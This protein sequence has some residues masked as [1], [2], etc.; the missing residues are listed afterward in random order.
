MAS[1]RP[2]A[3]DRALGVPWSRYALYSGT[4][5]VGLAIDLITKHLCFA[6]P[7]LRSG[8]IHW[9]WTG[10]VGIQLSLNEGALF[11]FGQGKV[12][13]FAIMSVAAA[14]AIPAW[15][16][17]YRAARDPWL[18]FALACVT[19]GVLGNLYDRLGLHGIAQGGQ[20]IYAVRDWILWQANDNWRWPNFNI[21]DSFL[22]VGACLL[23]LHALWL[24]NSK[25]TAA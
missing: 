15:L 16:F 7:E 8:D 12:W 23:F 3:A 20:T 11:G 24:P 18:T 9:L 21:A 2:T 19:V 4:A 25:A 14:I 6:S 1:E 10:H 13:L 22:V 17:I 5:V